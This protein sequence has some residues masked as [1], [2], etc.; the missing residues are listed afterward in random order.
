[1]D[2]K[3]RAR[4]LELR[5][6]LDRLLPP[7]CALCARPLAA[8]EV[9][10][11][12]VCWARAPSCRYPRCRRCGIPVAD[13][14]V[15]PSEATCLECR[16]WLPYLRECRAPYLMAG[17]AAAIV[18]ALKY[19][20]W[21]GLAAEMGERMAGER[22]SPPVGAEIGLVVPV[23]LSE[24]RRRQRGF[25]QAELLAQTVAD[26]LGLPLALDLLAR[27]RHTRRQARLAP[28]QRSRNVQG[29][30]AAVE[31]R[32]AGLAGAHVLLVDDV[33]TTGATAQAC[34]RALCGEGARAVSVLTFA[35]ARRVL[36]KR[37]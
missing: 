6:W 27:R 33:L 1:M 3:G 7:V 28:R 31:G 35:R 32:G 4:L 15:A 20:G 18:H 26:L 10:V 25:N 11:C 5:D 24:A 14:G 37:A 36:A 2:G 16:R 34:V 30:F 21:S 23:P 9:R 17:T 22:F 8:R 12:Q 29:A 19:R 13:T